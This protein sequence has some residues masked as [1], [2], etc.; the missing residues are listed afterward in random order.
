MI[1]DFSSYLHASFHVARYDK[2]VKD[3]QERTQYWKQL[4]VGMILNVK[5]QYKP[6]EVVLAIDSPNSHRKQGYPHSFKYYKARRIL[7]KEDSDIDW[8]EFNKVSNLMLDEITENL[9]VKCVKVD[10]SEAD[11]IIGIL[12][13]KLR[14]NDIT[15]V[16]R[17]K[18]FTQLLRF[19]NVKIH[20]PLDNKLIVCDNPKEFLTLH[21]LGGDSGDDVP[22]I[23]SPDNIFVTTGKRQKSITKGIIKEVL[24]EGLDKFVIKNDLLANYERNRNLVELSE[25][26]I[27]QDLQ[28]NIMY[29]YNKSKVKGDYE[30]MMGYLA[31]NNFTN[32]INNL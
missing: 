19:P 4:L 26:V 24:E 32:L 12:T 27:P 13:C 6:D 17:D 31:R 28:T 23:L 9:P 30:D 2:D 25:D 11:D 7:K 5:K 14:D 1:I 15:I 21:I 16:S 8:N 29:T 10:S 22:N 20:N 3:T 18:D